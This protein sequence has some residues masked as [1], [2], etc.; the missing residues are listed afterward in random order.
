MTQQHLDKNLLQLFEEAI[1]RGASDIAI[2]GGEPPLFKINGQ[3]QRMK[4]DPLKDSEAEGFLLSLI[5]YSENGPTPAARLHSNVEQDFSIPLPDGTRLRVNIFLTGSFPA[6]VIRLIPGKVRSLDELGLPLAPIENALTR[7]TGLILVT[8]ATGSGKSTSLAAMVDWLNER[9][10]IHIVTIEDPIEFFHQPKRAIITQ[11]EVGTDTQDFATAL[12]AVLRQA[13]DVILVG[14]MRDLETISSAI[15]AAE[16]GHLVMGTLH[17]NS[18]HEA[19]DRIIDVFPE[20]HRNLVRTQLASALSLV[21]CQALVP[22]IDGTGRALLCEVMVNTPAIATAI[23]EGKT[24]QIPNAIQTGR[25]WGMRLMSQAALEL[26]E[27]GIIS[28]E[29]ARSLNKGV[30]DFAPSA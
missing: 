27:Q 30:E 15:T 1:G 8:G 28:L 9:H 3:W 23:R 10:P 16:T 2:K 17:T 19:V 22:R 26:V 21:L 18:A 20:G 29:Q 12:R 4:T 24:G 25:N 6:A 13:P 14:E 11:R 7:K 5:P